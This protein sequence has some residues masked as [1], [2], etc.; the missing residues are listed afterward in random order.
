[1][2]KGSVSKY[3]SIV[4]L[5][6]PQIAVA[7]QRNATDVEAIAMR[8]WEKADYIPTQPYSVKRTEMGDGNGKLYIVRKTTTNDSLTMPGFLIVPAC[9]QMP[10]VLAYDDYAFF[11]HH[12]LPEHI[13]TWLKG[14]SEMQAKYE[15]DSLSL[16]QW[17]AASQGYADEVQP[18]LGNREWGQDNPYN[19]YCPIVNGE[20]CPSGCVAT[21]L[22]QIMCY[23]KWPET[24]TGSIHYRTGTHRLDISYDFSSTTFEWNN[25]R[26][27]YSPVM[28]F[29]VGKEDVVNNGLFAIRDIS[30]NDNKSNTECYI[31]VTGLSALGTSTFN[32]ETTML[33]IDDKEEAASCVSPVCA[34]ES[35]FSGQL[36]SSKDFLL[37]IPVSLPN[38][39]YYLY[40][41][42]RAFGVSEW[43]LS[44]SWTKEGQNFLTLTK[45][46]STFTVGGSTFACSLSSDDVRPIATLLQAVGAA[47]EMD[48]A[49]DGSGS[50]DSK[51]K[52]GLTTYLGYDPDM[53][54]AYPED[55]SDEQWHQLLQSELAAGRPVYYTGQGI[56]G[57][58]AFVI[59]GMQTD[60]TTGLVYYHV[61]WGWD[62]L[63]NGYYLL[64]MLR[65]SS[66]GTG[67]S[68]GSN[69]SNNPSM[70]IGMK[71]DDG[72]TE[73]KM[74]CRNLDVT[75]NELF[76]G[77]FLP[78][79]LGKLALRSQDNYVGDFRLELH[80]LSSPASSPV[81]LYYEPRRTITVERGLSNYYMPCLIPKGVTAGEYEL[82][83][84]C[85]RED[86]LAMQM[87]HDE[88][89]VIQIIDTTQWAGGTLTQP[90]QRL[91]L[92]NGLQLSET[93]GRLTV[94]VDSLVNPVQTFTSGQ[95]AVAICSAD[96]VLESVPTETIEI[97]VGALGVRRNV[98]V[99][100]PIYRQMPDG[101]YNLRIVYLPMD[102]S[103]WTFCDQMDYKGNILWSDYHP[104]AIGMSIMNGHVTIANEL[105]F[106]GMEPPYEDRVEKVHVNP[107]KE[108]VTYDLNG[109]RVVDDYQGIIV[110]KRGK[111][112]LKQIKRKR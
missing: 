28:E 98:N 82:V 70:L 54:F 51:T 16:R 15:V 35:R 88:W 42:V 72:V 105:E 23:H 29:Q 55:Y 49:P 38:G 46:D 1:M 64:N 81:T 111:Q 20:Q 19:L 26:D 3:I 108:G 65:P 61:N 67:G 43:S 92:G 90:L 17:L 112:Q 107:Y 83:V 79:R 30:L 69:Y 80:S 93:E 13:E 56:S 18:I 21:A 48:Y 95:L 59:D 62:G 25:M 110:R 97:A 68:S 103:L 10:E 22:S 71:P 63:C 9:R 91:A 109:R 24:G 40:N 5:W 75:R 39:S 50:N 34:V 6:L 58:H 4:L 100:I 52:R 85:T 37:Y 104:Y 76:P 27:A 32:G 99:S 31:Q 73:M 36:F 44:K 74:E 2:T 102:D 87:Q 8:Q 77:Q 12:Q 41:A 101:N 106:E 84:S 7:Q 66:A 45:E 94:S 11:Q 53:Y 96:S 89:P 14:Y 57:G 60:E 86:G 33:L 47:V 78:V